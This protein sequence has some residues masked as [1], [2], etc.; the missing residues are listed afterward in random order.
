M[1]ERRA[2]SPSGRP[3]ERRPLEPSSELPSEPP[4]EPWYKPL[5]VLAPDKHAALVA[6]RA[7]IAADAR[8]PVEALWQPLP[9]IGATE[10]AWI[11]R[12]RQH[13]GAGRCGLL[14]TGENAALDPLARM[15]AIAGCLSRNFVRARVFPL[16]EALSAVA[17]GEPIAATCLLIPDF[18]TARRAERQQPAWRQHHVTALL[19]E[20]WS[21]AAVQTVLYAP[22]LEAVAVEYGAYVRDLLRNH[23]IQAR[24]DA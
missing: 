15:G 4:V 16:H 2:K 14:L 5:G 6:R 18:A 8:I 11:A 1:T 23:F 13:R 20:R 21:D 22:T 9:A 24:I 17:N 19:T 10:R 12:F 7:E 3:S